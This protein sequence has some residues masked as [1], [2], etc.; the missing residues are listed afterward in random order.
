MN[1]LHFENIGKSV[2]ISIN[3]IDKKNTNLFFNIKKPSIIEAGRF[4]NK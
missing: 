3:L 4:L 1:N 2:K